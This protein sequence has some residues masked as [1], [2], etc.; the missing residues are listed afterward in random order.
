MSDLTYSESVVV[1]ATPEALY[2]LVSDVTRVGEWSAECRGAWWDDGATG[3]VGDWFTGRNVSG[4]NT[5]ETKSQVIAAE[6]GREFAFVVGGS[7]VRWGF[8]LAAA[9]GGTELTESWAFLP[10]G[11][12]FFR[13]RFGDEV[14][15]AIT[16][17]TETAR[18][19]IH[20]TL[21]AIKKIAESG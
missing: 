3:A 10:D 16:G 19:G 2:D 7:Y 17:R 14:D 1:A 21:A 9:E 6:R 4:E 13:D 11:I 8:T 5:W 20:D 18:T 12:A 15:A